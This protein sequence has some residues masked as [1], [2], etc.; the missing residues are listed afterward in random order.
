MS[1]YPFLKFRQARQHPECSICI[2]HKMAIRSLGHHLNARLK[3]LEEYHNHLH[4][5]YLDRL[6][7]WSS[8]GVSRSRG[9]ELTIICDGMDQGKFAY[10]RAPCMKSKD[11]A[12]WSRPRAH[13][14]GVLLHG[15]AIVFAVTEPDVPKDST[16]HVELLAICL[17]KLAHDGVQLKELALT[18]Q[19]DNTVRE[20]KNNTMTQFLASLVSKGSFA[21]TLIVF[22]LT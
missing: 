15:R 22:V 4:N 1:D 16:T 3:Q 21:L 19:C 9:N 17:T 10:P 6:A 11:F 20:C 12:S 8:R 2:K 13:V 18:L 5:Q 7:Y 14:I